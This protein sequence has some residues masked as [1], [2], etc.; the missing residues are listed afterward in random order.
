[1]NLS[2][3]NKR[4]EKIMCFKSSSMPIVVPA[5]TQKVEV[6]K[7]DASATKKSQ[8]LNSTAY[9]ENFKTSP[10]G[11]SDNAQSEKHTL[12]GE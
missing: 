12:L 9:R 11:L 10:I 4:K 6:H 3:L 8:N 1:M 7:A 5:E 2:R